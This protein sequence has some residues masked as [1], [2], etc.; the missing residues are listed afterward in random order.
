VNQLKQLGEASKTAHP[1]M[2]TED[3]AARRRNGDVWYRKI[4]ILWGLCRDFTLFTSKWLDL[5]RVWRYY[6]LA[7]SENPHVLAIF[8]GE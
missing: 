3:A 5:M 7:L 1:K 4:G 6:D 2:Q 8:K